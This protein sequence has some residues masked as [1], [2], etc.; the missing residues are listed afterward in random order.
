MSETLFP[1]VQ[2]GSEIKAGHIGGHIGRFEIIPISSLFVDSVYQR[3]I[4]QGSVKN[5]K[6]I[7]EGFDWAKFLPVIVTQDGDTFSIV[8]GQHRTTAAST[9]GITEVPCYVLSCTASE[10]A[11]AFAAING[12]VTPVQPIDLWF[13]ELAAKKPEAVA[14]QR[15][16]DASNVKITRKKEGFTAGE[17]RSITVLQR[18]LDFYGSAILTTILQCIVETSDGNPGMLFGAMI[19]GIG[20]AIRTKPEVLS[21]PA[22]LFDAF[23]EINLSEMLYAAKIESAHSGNPVQFIITRHINALIKNGAAREVANAA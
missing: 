13:A 5:I 15:V 14:L 20:R 17:T 10:A 4:S 23:D 12:N 11:A 22:R 19:N 3:A 8:D 21:N 2:L 7:C 9:I 16:L 18:A 6:R 1:I